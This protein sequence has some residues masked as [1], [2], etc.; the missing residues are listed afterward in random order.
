MA[1][2]NPRADVTSDMS[3]FPDIAEEFQEKYLHCIG[4]LTLESLSDNS[5]KR[6]ID[7]NGKN[8]CYFIKS[9]FKCQNQLGEFLDNGEWTGSSINLRTEKLIGFALE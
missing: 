7:F 3:I 8:A 2:Q 5:S 4:N 9:S 6:N 1:I